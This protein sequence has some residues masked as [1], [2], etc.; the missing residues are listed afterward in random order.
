MERSIRVNED[1]SVSDV[2]VVDGVLFS[3]I[4]RCTG[5]KWFVNV[6]SNDPNDVTVVDDDG[7]VSVEDDTSFNEIDLG[8]WRG[9]GLYFTVVA[10]TVDGDDVGDDMGDDIG[11]DIRRD[12]S[13]IGLR[14]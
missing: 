5:V 11:D 4:D 8:G 3:F 7:L 14:D 2:S 9:V 6:L 1:T 12:T 10:G 13:V